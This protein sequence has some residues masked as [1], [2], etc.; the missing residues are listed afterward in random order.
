M[1]KDNDKKVKSRKYDKGQIFIKI[2]AGILAG[3][4]ILAAC[5]TIVFAIMG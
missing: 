2:M 5:A 1:K 3:L 4:M